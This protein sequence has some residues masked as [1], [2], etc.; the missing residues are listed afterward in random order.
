MR[1][2]DELSAYVPSRPVPPGE[3]RPE[4]AVQLTAASR[5]VPPEG[6]R[7]TGRKSAPAACCRRA[8]TD[9]CRPMPRLHSSWQRRRP[10]RWHL[11]DRRGRLGHTRRG[12]RSGAKFN[13]PNSRQRGL[14]HAIDAAATGW[15]AVKC[16]SI[17]AVSLGG[18]FTP[19]A[20]NDEGQAPGS[21]CIHFL[22]RALHPSGVR[23][24]VRGRSRCACSRPRS[25]LLGSEEHLERSEVASLRATVVAT[26]ARV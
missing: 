4:V 26:I 21:T 7:P 24:P 9:G 20:T 6:V 23:N 3:D 16:A 11:A 18:V 19:P 12:R 22:D 14:A 17:S 2:A 1:S 13:S 10:F 5:V 25:T 8:A 15:A